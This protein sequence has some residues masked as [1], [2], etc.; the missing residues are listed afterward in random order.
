MRK[1]SLKFPVFVLVMAALAS[2]SLGA[3]GSDSKSSC[4]GNG[5]KEEGEACDGTDLGAGTTCASLTM[6]AN[7]TGTPTCNSDCTPNITTCTGAGGSG[8]GGGPNG[9]GGGP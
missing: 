9:T 8:T 4:N 3:C 7:S 6:N 5:V 1:F 2:S